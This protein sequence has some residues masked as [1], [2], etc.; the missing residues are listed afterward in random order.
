MPERE[1]FQ[2]YTHAR[3]IDECVGPFHYEDFKVAKLGVRN[4]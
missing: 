3:P 2:V 4:A 1:P